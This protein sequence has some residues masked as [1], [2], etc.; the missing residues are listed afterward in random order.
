MSA[1]PATSLTLV[2]TGLADAKLISTG[3]PNLQ[4]FLHVVKKTTRWAAQWCRVEFDGAPEFG[5]QVSLTVPTIAELINGLTIV[6]EMPDIYTPQLKAIQAAGGTDLKNKGTFLGP[7]FGWTNSLGHALIQTI[8]LEIGGAVVETLDSLLLEILDELHETAEAAATK[9]FM[10]KRTPYGFTNTTYL[11]ATPTTVYVPIPFWF[12]KPG[13]LSHALPIQA[14]NI[15]DVKIH[16]TFRPINGLAYTDARANPK[17]IGLET[18]PPF[19][20]PYA[21]MLPMTN[22]PFWQSAPPGPNTGPVYTMNSSM[23]TNPVNGKQIPGITMPARFS[24]ISAY[25]LIE[26]ISLEEDEAIAFRTAELTYQ[27]QQHQAVQVEQSLGQ[28][29]VH[30]DIPYSNPTKDMMWVLQRPEAT[31]YNAY[32]LFTR[33][34]YPTPTSQPNGGAIVQPNPTTI[35]WWPDAIF[36][37]VPVEAWQLQPAFRRAYSEP[38]AAAS[39]HYNSYERF[40]HE[41]GSFFRSVIPSQYFT[42][43]AMVDRYIYAYAFGLKNKAHEYEPKGSANWSKLQRKELYITLNPAR[44]GGPPPNMNIY[45]YITMW[46]VFKVYGGRGGLL[47][48]N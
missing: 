8:T 21:P 13:V 34:L 41:G 40:V 39:L 46:N 29:D 17:T 1:T 20:A 4:Q 42:K 26:Y 28:T 48:D 9:N 3:N 6:V 15:D 31:T 45:V 7:L 12:S 47:F 33:D 27:V 11:T 10:I 23:G 2:T 32:F 36:Q 24:P 16:V 30:I 38:L 22:S 35:P 43:S 25:A 14:L 5:Q 37:P 18:T 44:G 19:T